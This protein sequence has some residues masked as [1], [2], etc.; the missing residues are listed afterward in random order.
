MPGNGRSALPGTAHTSHPHG[1]V[2]ETPI[3]RLYA[4]CFYSQPG[5][6][7]MRVAAASHAKC[8]LHVSAI[9]SVRHG[10]GPEAAAP[11]IFDSCHSAQTADHYSQDNPNP[12]ATWLV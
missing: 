4:E 9:V 5:P 11:R 12:L 1:R 10:Y 8:C 7:V 3:T 2:L 6:P